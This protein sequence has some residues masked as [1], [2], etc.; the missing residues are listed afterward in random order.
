M[1]RPGLSVTALTGLAAARLNAGLMD[2]LVSALFGYALAILPIES[3]DRLAMAATGGYGRSTLAPFSDID[4][5]FL[6]DA[7][8][9]P[10]R[11]E[12]AVEFILYFLWD[13]GLKVG[14]AT[15]SI[16]ECLKDAKADVTIRTSLLDARCISGDRP[17]FADFQAAF[18][19]D[20]IADGPADYIA[21]KQ[22]P[23]APP[24]ISALAKPPFMVEP[25]VKEGRGGLRDLQTV[26]TGWRAMCSTPLR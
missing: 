16:P 14:H 21:A 13:L 23:N 9:A 2:E 25:N 10:L 5:L 1:C 22:V 7:K 6:T 18:R 19:A 15:R 8:A 26:C 17:L 4:L 12:R 11:V 24:G 20:C 3:Q